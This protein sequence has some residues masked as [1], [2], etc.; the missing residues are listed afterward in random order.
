MMEIADLRPEFA[1]AFRALNAA[2]ITR[3]YAM[4]PKDHEVLAAPE[5]IVQ[6][7]GSVLF[8]LDAGVVIGCCALSPMD[9]GGLEL[10]KMAV[11]EGRQGQGVGRALM[12]ACIARARESGAWRL[13]LES[14]LRLTPALTL[15][16]S[17]GFRDVPPERRP[18]SDYSRADVWMELPLQTPRTD[19]IRSD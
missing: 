9:D 8:A 14:G 18:R 7:G 16:R 6:R 2:W 15:Y 19:K 11:A 3:Y 17:V 1:P 5:R 12:A 4:E 10:G 13:Y